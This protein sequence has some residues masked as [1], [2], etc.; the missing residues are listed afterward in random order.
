MS[1][2]HP[3]PARLDLESLEELVQ[4]GIETGAEE[5]FAEPVNA[6]GRAL[7]HTIHALRRA[8]Y[9]I[10]AAA[11]D[12][13]RNKVAWS[14]YVVRLVA[15]LQQVLRRHYA[16]EKLRVLLYGKGLTAND[17]DQ[18]RQHPEGIVWLEGVEGA[19]DPP[20]VQAP[21]SQARLA[22]RA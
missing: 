15:N 9:D 18:I 12:R 4:I 2:R 3:Q 10:E 8:G 1:R 22:R 11:T 5:F 21:G 6:R 20:A 19:S 14:A 13:I 7:T 16:I 17:A